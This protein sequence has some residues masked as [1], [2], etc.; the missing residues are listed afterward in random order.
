VTEQAALWPS[1]WPAEDGGPTAPAGTDRRSNGPRTRPGSRLAR[2]CAPS[3][4][5]IAAR[6]RV[7]HGGAP[8][9]GRGLPALPHRRRR[10]DLVGRADRP[11]S[12]ST[13]RRRSPDLPG[14]P[15]VARRTRRARRR[16]AV[17]RVRRPPPPAL[18]RRSS[19]SP[20]A[21]LPRGT[22]RTTA[23]SCCP[24]VHLATKDFA[25]VRPG[26]PERRRPT[27][28]DLSCSCSDP[29]TLEVVATHHVARTLG[30]P[31]QRPR[32]TAIYVVC[33]THAVA[34]ALDRRRR[35]RSTARLRRRV[36][37][38]LARADLRVGR[39]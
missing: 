7:D 9:A 23:S 4:R 12:R 34:P 16:L 31:P 11:E 14:G 35:S 22:A 17:R 39:R 28:T 27:S 21:R 33:D 5:P 37:R 8:R 6:H 32:R 15:D 13:P 20:P 1:P 36:Y 3:H 18:V 19:C 10:R 24:T 30:G 38:T 2:R 25:G 26:A 29:A